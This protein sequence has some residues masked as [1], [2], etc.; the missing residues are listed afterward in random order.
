MSKVNIVLRS[1]YVFTSLSSLPVNV[2]KANFMLYSRV[3][4]PQDIDS[5]IMFE[6]KPVLQVQEIRY[7]GFY[8]DFNLSWKR[9]RDVVAAK[10][11]RGLSANG[12]F[13]NF[14]PP[15]V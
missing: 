3:G 14:L 12:R 10:V 6:N 5:S 11:A 4:K 7:L 2:A 15:R 9:H 1:F 13:K 8:I